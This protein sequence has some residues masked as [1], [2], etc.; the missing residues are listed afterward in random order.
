VAAIAAASTAG[1]AAAVP[2]LVGAA[3]PAYHDA[4]KHATILVSASMVVTAIAV[5]FVTAWWAARHPSRSDS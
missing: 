2:A 3:N 1:N 5:P 4:A